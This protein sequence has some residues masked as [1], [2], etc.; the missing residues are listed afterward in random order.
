MICWFL[1]DFVGTVWSC[2]G[3][4]SR[5]DFHPSNFFGCYL[6]IIGCL[7]FKKLF[8]SNF[9]PIEKC[10]SPLDTQNSVKTGKFHKSLAASGK[11][12]Q[13]VSA[14]QEKR[15]AEKC[16][17]TEKQ[18]FLRIFKNSLEQK[19]LK[20]G[21]LSQVDFHFSRFSPCQKAER[22][23][24]PIHQGFMQKVHFLV[25]LS[26]L[27]GIMW[28]NVDGGWQAFGCSAIHIT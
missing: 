24:I 15:I 14:L 23:W 10:D 6:T 8:A 16:W 7:C 28:N 22:Q 2:T 3:E 9:K 13:S 20:N 26:T 17:K 11:R 1:I 21:K 27:C 25:H 4:M 12:F 18:K 19:T 5:K